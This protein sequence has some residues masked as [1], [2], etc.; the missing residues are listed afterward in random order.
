M[1]VQGQAV[2]VRP[3]ALERVDQSRDVA[4]GAHADGVA[5]AELTRPEVEQASPDRDDLLDR[6][7]AFPGVAEAHRD[8]RADVDSGVA[9]TPYDG[10]EHR[11]LRVQRPVEALLGERLGGAAEDRD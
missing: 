3:G 2:D 9:R 4:G 6:Y 1:E 7:G 11:E 10:L 5:E 8:V